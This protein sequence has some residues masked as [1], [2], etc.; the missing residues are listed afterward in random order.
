MNATQYNLETFSR[1]RGKYQSVFY[2]LSDKIKGRMFLEPL[3]LT[4]LLLVSATP[5][6]WCQ[7]KTPPIVRVGLLAP[8]PVADTSR[9][10]KTLE[11]VKIDTKNPYGAHVKTH[12]GG[13]TDGTIKVEQHASLS[14]ASLG[15]QSCYW[16]SD[17]QITVHLVQKVYVASEYKYGSCMYNAVWEH[18]HKHVR[19]D[20]EIINKYRPVYEQAVLRFVT[21]AGAT[22]PVES[23]SA[24]KVQESMTQELRR[25]IRSVTDKME[26]ERTA[27]QQSIDTRA[28]YDRVSAQCRG[29]K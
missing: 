28:E 24:Q 21:Q 9:P 14:G 23:H 10:M 11:T 12:V 5:P 3:A 17:V 19:V 26:A 1:E 8:Q 13:L 16:Y 22:G 6:A 20:R 29:K 7:P 18:E 2:R 15:D 25:A 27:R 4:S